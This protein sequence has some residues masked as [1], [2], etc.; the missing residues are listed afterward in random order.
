MRPARRQP[1]FSLLEIMI[2]IMILGVGLVM[3]ATVFPVGL[4]IARQTLQ[5][6]ISQAVADSAMATLRLKVPGQTDLDGYPVSVWAGVYVPDVARTDADADIDAND[7]IVLTPTYLPPGM[8]ALYLNWTPAWSGPSS[9]R[10]FSERSGWTADTTWDPVSNVPRPI[11]SYGDAFVV[12]Y[13]NLP[14]QYAGMAVFPTILP[15]TFWGHRAALPRVHLLDQVYPPVPLYKDDAAG[16]P[17]GRNW[18]TEILPDLARR[19]YSWI[20]IHHRISP[21]PAIRD[22]LVT[23]LITHRSDLT[24]RFARQLDESASQVF[25]Y[26]GDP[27]DVQA[28][29]TPKVGAPNQDMLFPQAWLVLLNQVNPDAG[30]VVCT[31]QVARLLP[32][33]SSFVVAR[34]A[35]ALIGGT[36][37]EVLDATYNQTIADSHDSPTARLRIAKGP[38]VLVNNLLVWVVPPAY[39]R[40]SGTFRAKSPVAGVALR[41][42]S[43]K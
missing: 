30:D 14:P 28:L 31:Q 41:Q 18:M 39:D 2:A 16:Q 15:P 36:A 34:T 32:A 9:L 3:V 5:M 19:R 24:A 27:A 8:G 13:Q 1:A 35:G 40:A 12:P 22:L 26:T 17:V 23:I 6:N 10:A 29:K 4:D 37:H 7:Q 21:E 33:G 20:A 43:F 25:S 11:S 42:L 38:G